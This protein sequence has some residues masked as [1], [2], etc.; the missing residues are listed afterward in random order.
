MFSSYYHGVFKGI[1]NFT[2]LALPVKCLAP[3][4]LVVAVRMLKLSLLLI[5]T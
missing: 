3:Y 4:L 2:F 1:M 5:K